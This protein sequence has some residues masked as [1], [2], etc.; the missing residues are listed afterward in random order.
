MPKTIKIRWREKTT[1]KFL[2]IY[3]AKE[4]LWNPA[5]VWYK[6]KFKREKAYHEI[7][8]EF[9]AITGKSMSIPEVK[10]KIKNLRSTYS[11]EVQKIMKKS[12]P[13]SI[14]QPSL[15]WFHDM[16]RCLKYVPTNRNVTADFVST[17]PQIHPSVSQKQLEEQE[18]INYLDLKLCPILRSF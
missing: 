5:H 14:Y 12:S 8:S 1:L 16:D 10:I 4:C 3:L 18:R 2:K 6:I 11:Q 13:D 9:K 15:V 17:I 7:V